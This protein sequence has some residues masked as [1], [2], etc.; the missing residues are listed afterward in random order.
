LG[1]SGLERAVVEGGEQM[2]GVKEKKDIRQERW[3][4][5]SIQITEHIFSLMLLSL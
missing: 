3:R 2:F 1:G 5:L 4:E